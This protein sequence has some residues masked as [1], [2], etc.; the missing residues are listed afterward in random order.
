M[1]IQNVRVHQVLLILIM[2]LKVDVNLPH[3]EQEN[4]NVFFSFYIKQ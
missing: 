1:L 2:E 3:V 4:K